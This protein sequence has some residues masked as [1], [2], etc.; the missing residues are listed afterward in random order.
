[1]DFYEQYTNHSDTQILEILKKRK[2]Y[3]DAA[4]D[5]A[6]KIAIERQLINS[7]Q[8][9][10]SPEL[11]YVKSKD[12]KF[13]PEIQNSYQRQKLAG[14]IFRFLYVMSFLPVVYGFL[15]YAEGQ[16]YLTFIGIG[17]G[18]L[19]F[20]LSFLLY[21]TQK[22][23]VIIPL[24]ILLFSV[25]LAV[26]SKIISSTPFRFLDLMMLIIG[27]LLPVYLLLLLKKLIQTK[28]DSE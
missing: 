19:W 28:P 11:Q 24:L 15:K 25:S 8:D 23:V 16:L 10:F 2:D 6:I 27:T 1:M 26:G 4:V 21:K 7:E 20:L 12:S 18:L 14:S 5:A 22:I 9:L 17:L 3:Q 13:L